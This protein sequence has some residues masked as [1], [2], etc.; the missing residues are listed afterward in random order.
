MTCI[1]V[2][3][4]FH[5]HRLCKLLNFEV[6]KRTT[7]GVKVIGHKRRKKPITIERIVKLSPGEVLLF[8]DGLKDSWSLSSVPINGSPH[9]DLCVFIQAGQDI[10]ES[11][12]V[13]RESTGTLDNRFPIKIGEN[14]MQLH[15]D[16]SLKCLDSIINAH[17]SHPR[18]ICLDDKYY[19]LDGKHRL[20]MAACIGVDMECDVL[21]AKEIFD[22]PY[23]QNIYRIM[24]KDHR[25]YTKNLAILD[26]M[27]KHFSY[28]K[29]K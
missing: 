19:V 11:D 20:A 9:K 7:V 23:I 24:K 16:L 8:V 17:Y 5:L 6:Y 3:C 4:I 13:L 2:N 22:S 25:S 14:E 18:V 26:S 10:T 29:N 15:Q 1:L 12:Y 27:E 28:P 21:S